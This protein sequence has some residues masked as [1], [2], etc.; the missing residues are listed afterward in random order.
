MSDRTGESWARTGL[1]AL[2][3][4]GVLT[5][6]S[7]LDPQPDP[8]TDHEAWASFVTTDRYLIGHLLGSGLGLIMAIFGTFAL[9]AVLSGTRVVRPAL[10]GTVT[11]V[12]AHGVF[13][14]LMANSAF[15]APNSARAYLAGV[16]H[17]D[18]IIESPH[19][20]LAQAVMFGIVIVFSFVGNVLLGVAVWRSRVLPRAA[21][22]AWILSAVLLYP[23]GL[24]VGLFFTHDSPPTEPLGAATVAVAGA[25]MALAARRTTPTGSGTLVTT[26]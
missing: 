26:G 14:M 17:I 24:I 5:F 23:A 21:G 8:G 11:A 9:A 3:A 18:D 10:I 12:L 15:A 13:L 6:A 25:W 1:W 22:A 4:Y 19:S 20:A 2:S 7:S 16:R